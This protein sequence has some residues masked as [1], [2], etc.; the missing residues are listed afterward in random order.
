MSNDLVAVSTTGT[1]AGSR[2]DGGVTSAGRWRRELLTASR[3]WCGGTDGCVGGG[4]GQGEDGEVRLDAVDM[5]REE[6][7]KGYNHLHE[8]GG[9]QVLR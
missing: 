5:G 2:E 6:M 7:L 4:I 8:R 9:R 1:K 3:G